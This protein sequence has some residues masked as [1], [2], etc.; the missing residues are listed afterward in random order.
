MYGHFG[1]GCVHLR[2][3]FDFKTTASIAKYRQFIDQA[4]DIV[5]K[6]GGSFSGEHGDG[7][8]RACLLPKMF[9]PELMQAF[10]AF[11]AL[12]DPLNRMNPGKLIDPV[13]VYD[14]TEN[15]R[16]GAGYTPARQTT[17][18]QYPGDHGSFSDATTRCVGV[19]ACR[20]QDDDTMC[21]SFMATREEK[22]STRGRAHLL[23]EMM[24]GNVIQDGWHSTEVKEALDLCLSCKACKIE[25]PVNVDMATWEAEFLAH[26][27]KGRLHPLHHYAFGF[28]DRWAHLASI[29]PSLANLPL[30]TPGLRNLIKS[31]IG[32]APQRELPRFATR[33]SAAIFM[34]RK[35]LSIATRS[36]SGPTLGTT[37][38][39]RRRCT[40]Q[41]RSSPL[42]ATL[43]GFQ[44]T[45]CA[46]A[47]RF[48][49][50]AFWIRRAATC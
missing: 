18:F 4:A 48:T 7:Q 12:W 17:W 40:R 21:P 49:T 24:Q 39:I 8:A 13:A 45:T 30:R 11:K 50:S 10:A 15:L 27:Y 33:N 31:V 38:F 22:H 5:L 42:P 2:I 37:T 26:H 46:V 28:M 34:L 23:W 3:T 9:G 1:Q 25:C 47:V 32:V 36:C 35:A 44:S 20:K 43:C 41:P 6:Y 14:A 16:I 29:A 19:G